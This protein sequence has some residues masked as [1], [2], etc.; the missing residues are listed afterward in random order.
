[1]TKGSIPSLALRNSGV[2]AEMKVGSVACRIAVGAKENGSVHVGNVLIVAMMERGGCVE[3]VR[4]SFVR[5]M[6]RGARTI[7]AIPAAETATAKEDSGEGE[8]RM[9]RPPV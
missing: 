9:S 3:G 6:S 5:A 8:Q 1:M 7:P 4:I 2:E